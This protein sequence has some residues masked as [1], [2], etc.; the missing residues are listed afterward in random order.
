MTDLVMKENQA[1]ARDL[2]FEAHKGQQRWDGRP[3]STH[4]EKVVEILKSWG[5]KDDRRLCAA[6][7]HDTIEDTNIDKADLEMIFGEGIANL[8]EELTFEQGKPDEYYWFKCSE[9]SNDAKIIKIADILANCSDE[10]KKSNHFIEKRTKAMIIL[11]R[12][13]A[14]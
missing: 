13:L 7:L 4:P 3:F 1:K 2:M 10:G 5:V 9:M 11:M 12:N 8:V 14:I 6:Y